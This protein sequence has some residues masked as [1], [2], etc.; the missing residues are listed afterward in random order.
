[1]KPLLFI[2]FLATGILAW[3]NQSIDLYISSLFFK[4][5][6]FYLK[7]KLLFYLAY[8]FGTL[9]AWFVGIACLV[10][11]CFSFVSISLKA[12]KPQII[13][14]LLSLIIGPGLI[15]NVLLKDNWGRPRP[16]QTENFGGEQSYQ[17]FYQPNFNNPTPSKSFPSGHASA[18]FYFMSFIFLARRIRN[19]EL[20]QWGRNLTL[21]LGLLLGITRIV[22]GGHYFSDVWMSAIVVFLTCLCLDHFY[23]KN[24]LS[25]GSKSF[26]R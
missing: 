25:S 23:L 3:F 21:S 19:E 18:G 15:V 20:D 17:K 26:K 7:D 9:P 12:I 16:V 8:E 2:L 24:Q 6:T 5:N 4:N 10:V 1:M 22:Q 13:Y 14:L 11:Y